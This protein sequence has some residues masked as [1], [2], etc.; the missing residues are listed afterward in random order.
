MHLRIRLAGWQGQWLRYKLSPNESAQRKANRYVMKMHVVPLFP[1]LLEFFH[2][3]SCVGSAPQH[4]TIS[5]VYDG[6]VGS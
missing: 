5:T 2:E 6:S 4:N 1:I 3:A